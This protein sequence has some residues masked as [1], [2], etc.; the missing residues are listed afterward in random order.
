MGDA[1]PPPDDASQCGL[2]T[3]GEVLPKIVGCSISTEME[4]KNKTQ[5]ST[6]RL[7][8]QDE[9]DSHRSYVAS[10]VT[11]HTQ[12]RP[13]LV[14]AVVGGGLAMD[15]TIFHSNTTINHDIFTTSSRH[16]QPR[17]VD[18]V[19]PS[20]NATTNNGRGIYVTFSA[21]ASIQL[22]QRSGI[23]ERAMAAAS[24]MQ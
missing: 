6:W 16:R 4:V 3:S 9:D 11:N 22:Q 20:A 5:Q 8:K 18:V 13:C 12:P 23:Y 2:S 17:D 10:S 21:A 1:S 19:G 15:C 7:K 14:R 24:T